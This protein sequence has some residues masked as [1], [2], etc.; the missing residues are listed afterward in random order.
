MARRRRCKVTCY[1]LF[2]TRQLRDSGPG[3]VLPQ[4]ASSCNALNCDARSIVW[5]TS[6]STITFDIPWDERTPPLPFTSISWIWTLIPEPSGCIG[7][8]KVSISLPQKAG[9]VNTGFNVQDSPVSLHRSPLHLHHPA[10]MFPV[11]P[12]LR[13]AHPSPQESP[14]PAMASG[15]HR[16]TPR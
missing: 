4:C 9:G 14:H 15:I 6:P 11:A 10:P 3:H 12:T 13:V 16:M 5:F 7:S 8:A 1:F 2:L